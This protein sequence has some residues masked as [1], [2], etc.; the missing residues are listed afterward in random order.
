MDFKYLK[1]RIARITVST[2]HFH[3]N[4]RGYLVVVLPEDF[5][6][7]D[8][9]KYKKEGYS[10]S[11]IPIICGIGLDV[12]PIFD[13]CGMCDEDILTKPTMQDFFEINDVLRQ[14]YIQLDPKGE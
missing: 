1:K 7:F 2:R 13:Y 10:F 14:F 6:K 8:V 11:F 4:W 9:K 12:K 5:D 3:D